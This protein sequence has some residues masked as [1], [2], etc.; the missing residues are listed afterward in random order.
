[1]FFFL[2]MVCY[3][4]PSFFLLCR[5]AE[6]VHFWHRRRAL[7]RFR[8]APRRAGFILPTALPTFKTVIR[9]PRCLPQVAV[10][11]PDFMVI[12]SAE[13]WMEIALLLAMPEYLRVF[14]FFKLAG[15]LLNWSPP[16]FRDLIKKAWFCRTIDQTTAWDIFSVVVNFCKFDLRL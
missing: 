8:A 2:L 6:A 16:L 3:F 12:P 1:M 9:W 14:L 15:C 13:A 10:V 11:L 4:A 7:T 5:S